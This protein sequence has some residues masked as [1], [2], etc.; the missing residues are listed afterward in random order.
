MCGIKIKMA[1]PMVLLRGCCLCNRL[2]VSS[3][4]FTKAQRSVLTRWSAPVLSS[5]AQS[6]RP[7]GSDPPGHKKTPQKVVI[8]GIP[9]PF[10]WLRM[11]A[12]YFLFRTYFDNDFSI[13]EFTEAAKQASLKHLDKVKTCLNMYKL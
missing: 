9:N 1:L 10:L 5:Q 13:D 11:R 3:R 12:Y 2:T 4:L 6:V 8:L 7:Y